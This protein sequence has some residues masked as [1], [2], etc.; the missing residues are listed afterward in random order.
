MII[1]GHWKKLNGC[2]F[3]PHIANAFQTSAKCLKWFSDDTNAVVMCCLHTR[4]LQWKTM[5]NFVNSSNMKGI[6]SFLKVL[7]G[8]EITVFLGNLNGFTEVLPNSDFYQNK[9]H[10]LNT[11]HSMC[12][13]VCFTFL[14]VSKW[15]L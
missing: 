11:K 2:F 7:A 12:L 15:I 1:A 6:N 5:F 13:L 4:K 14:R 9:R 10:L 3:R 8:H